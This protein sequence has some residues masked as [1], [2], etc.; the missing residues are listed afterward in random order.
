M[1]LRT[2]SIVQEVNKQSKKVKFLAPYVHSLFTVELPP[3][4]AHLYQYLMAEMLR[5]FDS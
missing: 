1:N 3:I 4:E 5:A 2:T